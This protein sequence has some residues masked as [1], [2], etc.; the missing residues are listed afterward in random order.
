MERGELVRRLVLNAICDDYEN[1]DQI[2]LP[3]VIEDGAECGLKNVQRL[4]IVDA[5]T[6]LVAQ[7]LAAAFTLSPYEPH[8]VP[9][10][11]MPSA[12]SVEENFKTYF[13]I[14]QKGAQLHLA[15]SGPLKL[16]D[17]V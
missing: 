14:T 12:D 5:L 15:D 7:G 11:G 6:D 2:I 16:D 4:E 17:P 10:D 3:Q 8:S 9:I 1:I 13:L